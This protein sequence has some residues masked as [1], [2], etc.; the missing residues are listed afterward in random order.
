MT[1]MVEKQEQPID[2]NVGAVSLSSVWSLIYGNPQDL[3]T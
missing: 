3:I 1:K 2:L